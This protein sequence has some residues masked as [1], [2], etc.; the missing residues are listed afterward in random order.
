[1]AGRVDLQLGSG[2]LKAYVAEK[3]W[4]YIAVE[5]IPFQ[6]G[7]SAAFDQA[8]R[9]LLR[10]SMGQSCPE[11]AAE[12]RLGFGSGTSVQVAVYTDR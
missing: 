3:V 5:S 9:Q 4:W 6:R 1:M 12:G 2:L 8:W 7:G 11:K 10:D